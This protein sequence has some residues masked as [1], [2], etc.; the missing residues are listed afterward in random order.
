MH[1]A[2]PSAN[3]YAMNAITRSLRVLGQA[4]G[5]LAL[6]VA[7]FSTAEAATSD[8]ATSE[9]GRMRLV[10]LAPDVDGHV[11]AALQIEPG[12]GWITYWREPGESGIPPQLSIEPGSKATIE[13]IGYPVPKLI[14]LGSIRE[15]GYDAPISL[16]LDIQP[17]GD[18]KLDVTA[19]IGVCKDIC[20]P[21]QAKLTV[22]LAPSG[23]PETADAA[24]VDAAKASLP[25]AA[26]KDFSVRNFALSADSKTLSLQLTLPDDGDAIPQLYLTGPSG[27][28]FSRQ[29][30]A[31]RHG[32][33][34]DITVA[35]GKLPKS[36]TI[37]GKSWG[38]LAV[39][40]GRAM[41]T[42]LAFP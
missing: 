37:N 39:D 29:V 17:N 22:T 2:S 16:P 20:I 15:V 41:E 12:P 30:S 27:T 21:F 19:F 9:G 7:F 40:G 34:A 36:Y 28:V 33:N 42:T 35:I 1:V 23:T 13:K 8:W 11:R 24:I 3:A 5:A 25:E 26:S 10:A 31:Q 14:T 38:L 6:A 32:R 18:S 4:A